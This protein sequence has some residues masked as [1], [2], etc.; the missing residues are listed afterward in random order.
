MGLKRV[1][2]MTFAYCCLVLKVQSLTCELNV[3]IQWSNHFMSANYYLSGLHRDL[4]NIVF[5]RSLL[6]LTLVNFPTESFPYLEFKPLLVKII[7]VLFDFIR[8]IMPLNKTQNINLAATCLQL[9][10]TWCHGSSAWQ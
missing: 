4:L 5:T 6:L 1:I 3:V 9:E 2:Q 10:N 8:S 7:N